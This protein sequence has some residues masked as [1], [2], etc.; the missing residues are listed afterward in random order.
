MVTLV[1]TR[2]EIPATTWAELANRLANQ[3]PAARGVYLFFTGAGSA[4]ALTPLPWPDAGRVVC[5]AA[6]LQSQGVW[7]PALP[8]LTVGGLANLGRL[9]RESRLTISLP[10]VNWPTHPGEIGPKRVA[11]LL[12]DDLATP[13]AV[14]SLRLAVGLAGCQHR[15]TL[16]RDQGFDGNPSSIDALFPPAAKPYLDFLPELGVTFRSGPVGTESVIVR[17]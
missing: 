17:V 5:A 4:L 9:V 10:L 8:G 7:P 16:Y 13:E 6:F 2:H 14:E 15:V 12:G 1:I 3:Q 11:I